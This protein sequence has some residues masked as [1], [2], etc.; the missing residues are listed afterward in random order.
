M[1]NITK[2]GNAAQPEKIMI[3]QQRD[4]SIRAIEVIIVNHNKVG[5]EGQGLVL[6][7]HDNGKI[8][9]RSGPVDMM[10]GV[11]IGP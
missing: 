6:L 9:L 10:D 3:E 8:T 2:I 4:A 11:D 7:C 1:C 5:K